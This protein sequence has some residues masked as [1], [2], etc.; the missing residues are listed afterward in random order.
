MSYDNHNTG[1]NCRLKDKQNTQ[2][3]WWQTARTDETAQP[4]RAFCRRSLDAHARRAAYAPGVPQLTDWSYRWCSQERNELQSPSWRMICQSCTSPSR[5]WVLQVILLLTGIFMGTPS[6]WGQ[7]WRLSP[8]MPWCPHIILLCHH[9][10]CSGRI[11]PTVLDE[12]TGLSISVVSLSATFSLGSR[13]QFYF[14][15]HPQ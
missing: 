14:L 5:R 10:H 3:Q 8:Q 1:T 13:L 4:R 15:S 12:G 11:P 7:Y 9:Q 6:L 2:P